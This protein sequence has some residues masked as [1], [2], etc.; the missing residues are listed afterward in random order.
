MYH[1]TVKDRQNGNTIWSS[2]DTTVV[3]FKTEEEAKQ[4]IHY[5]KALSYVYADC[6]LLIEHEEDVKEIEVSPNA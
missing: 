4:F 6:D 5:T 1:V 2:K 3:P